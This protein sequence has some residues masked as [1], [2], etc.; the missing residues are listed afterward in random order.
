MYLNLLIFFA[1]FSFVISISYLYMFSHKQERVLQYWGF[2]WIAYSVSL[3]FLVIYLHNQNI[4]LLELRKVVDM[5]NLLFLLFSSYALIHIKIPAYWYRFS[6]YLVLLAMI[7]M[8]YDFDLYAFY[9][10]IT[11]YQIVITVFTIYIIAKYWSIAKTEKLIALLVFS[12]WG[13]GKALL[14]FTVLFSIL[15]YNTYFIEIVLSNV[16]NFCILTIYIEFMRNKS[17]LACN[18][19][20]T[21]VDNAKDAIFYYRIKPYEAFEYVSPS[22]YTLT[23]YPPSD[24]YNNP[25]IYVQLVT[26]NYFDEVEDA[27][28]GKIQHTDNH[29]MPIIRKDGQTFWGEMNFDVMKNEKDGVFAV[30]ATLRDISIFKYAELTQIDAKENRNKQ[31]SYISHELR[32][33]I[34]VI[35]GYLTAMEDGILNS[36]EERSEAMKIITSKTMLLKNLIDDLE[37]LSKLE[38]HEF[39]FDFM[40][41]TITDIADYLI[42]A[43]HADIEASGFKL[44][45][46]YD[47]TILQNYWIIADQNRINQVFSNIITNAIKYSAEY[48]KILIRFDLDTSKDYFEISVR[49]YGI[50]IPPEKLP[51]VFD[52]F[53][54]DNSN[55]DAI[56]GRGLGLTICKEIV[57]AHGGIITAESNTNFIGSK[58]TFTIPLYKEF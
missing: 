20:Q 49:D 40:T 44:E 25:R 28:H 9:L 42:D 35:A 22:V 39:T 16:V 46:I 24:F 21:V 37:Q 1:I 13:I 34:T 38:T 19:Y 41:Y 43:N 4:L 18:L 26:E 5:F 58:F 15:S 50:G 56:K 14:S 51:H 8:M 11:V 47:R 27:F 2:S 55:P 10:P 23:G 30:E 7:C 53:F 36:K 17:D 32:T 57:R 48:K 29:I 52:R 3:L 45:L 54:R 6:L 12:I 33:P 31:L